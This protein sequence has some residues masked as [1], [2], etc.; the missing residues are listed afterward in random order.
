M[1]YLVLR[2]R[3]LRGDIVIL[4]A[5][6]LLRCIGHDFRL[7]VL[8]KLMKVDAGRTCSVERGV[9]LMTRGGVRIGPGSNICGG[10]IL[11]G[12]GGLYRYRGEHLPRSCAAQ[13]GAVRLRSQRQSCGAG[14]TS[15]GF[16]LVFGAD[17]LS[18]SAITPSPIVS[19]KGCPKLRPIV[20]DERVH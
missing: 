3:G 6:R 18:L 2:A 15:Y 4:V 13:A 1:R 8:R 5:N 7:L 14:S 16:R 19:C 11:D 10:V 9:R 17:C 20:S 12:R